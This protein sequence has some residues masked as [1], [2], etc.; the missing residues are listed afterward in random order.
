MSLWHFPAVYIYMGLTCDISPQFIYTVYMGFW[1]ALKENGNKHGDRF[2]AETVGGPGVNE[3]LEDVTP[4][5][6]HYSRLDRHEYKHIGGR[7]HHTGDGTGH[8]ARGQPVQGG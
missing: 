8:P 2:G 4:D 5:G 6:K 3:Q 1:R 7:G